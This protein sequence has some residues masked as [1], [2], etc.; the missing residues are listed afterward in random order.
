MGLGVSVGV[1]A[2]A[3]AAGTEAEGVAVTDG[4]VTT[5]VGLFGEDAG[6]VGDVTSVGEGVTGAGVT[7]AFV[8][9]VGEGV[10][11]RDAAAAGEGVTDGDA[12]ASGGVGLVT[13]LAKKGVAV[14][15]SALAD[16]AVVDGRVGELGVTA[17]VMSAVPGG[18]AGE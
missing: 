7:A 16:A 9:S 1:T 18:G 8:A 12:V 15:G 4:E 2:T 13:A 11:N 17:G 10:Y 5:S 6:N 3:T 14:G